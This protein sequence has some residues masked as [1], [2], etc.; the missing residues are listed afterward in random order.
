LQEYFDRAIERALEAERPVREADRAE[1][2]AEW[3]ERDAKWADYEAKMEARFS[4]LESMM[5]QS[6]SVPVV[7]QH[8]AMPN[9][10]STPLLNVRS[11]VGSESGNN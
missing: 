8:I 1:R 2:E 3:A 4:H 6:M 5:R 11:S 10:D 9:R 7:T